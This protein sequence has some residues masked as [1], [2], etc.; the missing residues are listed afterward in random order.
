[1]TDQ[2]RTIYALTI[3][4]AINLLNFFDRQI[5]GAV[6]EPIRKEWGL[7]DSA[8]GALGTAFTLLYAAAGV[9]L[10]RLTD[11]ARR[12]WILSAGVFV[13]S[14]LTAASGLARNFWQLFAARLGVGVGEATCAPAATSL[15]GDLFPASRRGKALSFF[16]LGLPIGL[17]LSYGASGAI[18][19]L[20]GWRA[21]FYFAGIPGLLCA[22]AVLFID[23][24]RRGAF[25]ERD[26]GVSRREGS[27]YLLVLSIPTMWWL[28][29][30][31]VLHNFNMYAL[32][33]FL[34]PFLMRFYN[35]DIRDSNFISMIIF[36]V[37][38]TAGLLL[39]GAASDLMMKRRANGRLLAGT[40]SLFGSIPLI[41]LALGRSSGDIVT[42]GALMVLAC[43]LMYAYY[44]TVYPAIHDI[45]EPSLRGTAMA[46]YFFGMYVMGASMGPLGT[47]MASDFF[48]RRAAR[49]AGITELTQH[50]LEPFRAQGLHSA[51][52]IVPVLGI[53]LTL[54]LFAGSCTVAK[55][56]EKLQRWMRQMVGAEGRA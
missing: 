45:I 35:V 6:T 55:D 44:S 5:L 32:S 18:A 29:L 9:P 2:Q 51:M 3:L 17:A 28:I 47:G 56:M 38:G 20:Y 10:G 48:T 1:M 52:Y 37:A 41:L 49:A 16:M 30:S 19:R 13:W 26:V 25:E 42:F 8:M 4:F 7:S 39:G 50:S 54:V 40:I 14:F 27:P 23:E 11:R 24:P 34:T 22:A 31:G 33:S 12:T 15:I 36:G 43:T 46:L 21:A 53:L